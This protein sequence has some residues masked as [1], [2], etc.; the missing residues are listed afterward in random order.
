MNKD[1]IYRGCVT[2]AFSG[3]LNKIQNIAHKFYG[4]ANVSVSVDYETNYFGGHAIRLGG[5]TGSADI[6]LP[7]SAEAVVKIVRI[8]MKE[9]EKQS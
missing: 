1:T 3:D 4:K 2:L 6:N 8:L 7:I 9:A 5:H